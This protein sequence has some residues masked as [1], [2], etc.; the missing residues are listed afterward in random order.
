MGFSPDSFLLLF[1]LDIQHVWRHSFTARYVVFDSLSNTTYHLVAQDGSEYLQYCSWVD[2]E[3]DENILIY[4][5]KNN[6]YWKHDG[7]EEAADNDVAITNDG[8]VDNVFNGIPDWVYE[9]EVLQSNHAI[10]VSPGGDKLAFLRFND[11]Q[12]F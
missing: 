1:A 10:H 2:N 12:R 8:E 11:R 7:A 5:S 9:E 6:L 3:N 4:A